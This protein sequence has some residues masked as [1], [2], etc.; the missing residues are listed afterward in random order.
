MSYNIHHDEGTFGYSILHDGGKY[1]NGV[2]TREKPLAVKK[3]AL[4]VHPKSGLPVP[5]IPD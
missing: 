5:F 1:G 4:P 3:H 2:L